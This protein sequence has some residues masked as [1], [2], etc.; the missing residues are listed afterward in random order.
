[1]C[2]D[3]CPPL[4]LLVFRTVL[5]SL[6][7]VHLV[8]CSFVQKATFRPR[9]SLLALQMSPMLRYLLDLLLIFSLRGSS[10]LRRTSRAEAF[11]HIVPTSEACSSFVTVC[12]RAGQPF[13]SKPFPSPVPPPELA[14][15]SP[16]YPF[17]RFEN[18]GNFAAT[19]FDLCA[20]LLR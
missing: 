8:L 15:S 11:S 7:G 2:F 4:R 3:H 10:P 12:S 5:R 9:Y 6:R 17:P 13:Y 20:F 16:L 1:V 14:V 18:R 19:F